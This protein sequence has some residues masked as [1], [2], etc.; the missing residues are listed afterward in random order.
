[1]HPHRLLG[2]SREAATLAGR[3]G[4]QLVEHVQRLGPLRGFQ[5]HHPAEEVAEQAEEVAE[6]AARRAK[7]KA[8]AAR[9]AAEVAADDGTLAALATAKSCGVAAAPGRGGG[10]EDLATD[11]AV[12]AV[13]S[14]RGT[15]E[16]ASF[17]R[18]QRSS[19]RA[20]VTAWW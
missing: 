14:A 1:M 13:V 7:A 20:T 16:T 2:A 8:V 10:V 11:A 15:S 17:S 19:D 6:K 3:H 9:K 5:E 12:S 4:L 18:H